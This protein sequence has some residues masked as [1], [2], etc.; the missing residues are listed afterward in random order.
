MLCSFVIPSIAAP[1]RLRPSHFL[2]YVNSAIKPPN[3]VSPIMRTQGRLLWKGEHHEELHDKRVLLLLGT[4]TAGPLGGLDGL[5]VALGGSLHARHE[6]GG[7]L[8]GP[9]EVA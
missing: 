7:G 4:T 9:L 6:T 5:L 8:E 3:T 1:N 2:P